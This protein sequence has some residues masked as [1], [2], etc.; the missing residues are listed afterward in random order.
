[1]PNQLAAYL[2]EVHP[3]SC[4]AC[5]GCG[6]RSTTASTPRSPP[7]PT[8]KAKFDEGVAAAIE[9]KARRARRHRHPGAARHV[10]V[11]RRRRVRQRARAGRARRGAS[12]RSPARRRS[13]APILEWFNAIGVPLSR[14]LRHERVERT[15]DVVARTQQ[16]RLRRP[17]DPRL[18][19]DDRRRRRGHLPR[20]QRV[21]GLLRAA[22]QDG[23][24]AHR[25]LAAH[26]RHRRDR[27]RRLP[28]SSTARRS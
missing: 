9:I 1:M 17:G 4:S 14:D 24:D 2:K 22:R 28:R 6:R 25:R 10:G 3:R 12:P 13:R 5:R 7:T 27:R 23:R 8:S 20:R 11:P 21:P 19:G 18:R 15:D 16:A 26:R